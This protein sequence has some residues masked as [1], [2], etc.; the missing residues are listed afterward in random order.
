LM[1]SLRRWAATLAL[2]EVGRA[3]GMGRRARLAE[4]GR[5]GGECR[6]AGERLEGLSGVF[7]VAFDL[8]LE[9]QSIFRMTW[10]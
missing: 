8:Q 7:L 5:G 2:A 9:S 10:T 6:S 4:A 3:V 1:L